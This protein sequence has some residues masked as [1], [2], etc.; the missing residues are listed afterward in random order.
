MNRKKKLTAA[1]FKEKIFVLDGAMGTMLQRYNLQENDYRGERFAGHSHPLKGNGDIL[2]LTQPHI[3]RDIHVA[4]LDAGADI[5]ET[6][7]FNA[8]SISQADYDTQD[9]VEEINVEAARLAVEAADKFMH[10]HPGEIKYVAGVMGPTNKT[11]SLSPDVNN[12]GYRNVSF[13]ELETTYY[14]QAV[15]LARGGVDM[16]LIETVFDTLNAKAALAAISRFNKGRKEKIRAMVSGTITDPSGRT[17]IGQ[18][19]SG[20]YAA[21]RHGDLLSV[22]LNCAFGASQLRPFIRELSKIAEFPVSVHPN[23]GLPNEF[24]EYEQ[25]AGEMAGILKEYLEEGWVNILG[26]CC[27]TTPE[28]VRQVFR[29]AQNYQPRAIPGKQNALKIAGLEAVTIHS[30]K[31]FVNIGERTNVAGSKRFARLIREEQFEE[32]LEVARHQIEN[33]AQVIDICMDDAMLDGKEAMVKFLRNIQAEP[34]IAIKPVMID[35]SDWKIIEE[36]LKNTSGKPIVNS[37]SLKEG[38]ED[39]LQKAETLKRYGA[40]VVVMLFDEQGQAASYRDKIRIARRS[41]DLLTEKAEFPAEDIIFDPN[42]LAVA[43]GIEEHNNYAVDFLNAI[44]WIKENLPHAKISGGVSN[45]SFSFRGNNRVREALHSVFLYH[46]TRAG[47]DMGIVNPALLE[48]YDD[49]DKDLKNLAE[50][51][52]LNKRKDATER[53]ISF[54]ESLSQTKET[55]QKADEWRR[56]PLEERIEYSLVKGID[57]YVEEDAEQ[58]RQHFDSIIDIIE[59]PLMKGMDV[60]GDLFGSGKMFLPQVVKSARVMKKAVGYLQPF[61]EKEL[62][63]GAETS[64]AGRIVLAT[65]KGDVHDI[66]KNIV[67]VILTCNNYEVIDLG[68]MVPAEKI[69]ETAEKVK[70]DIIGLSGLITPSLHEMESVAH[71]MEKRGM[72]T[73]LL[74]GGATTSKEHTAVKIAPNYSAPV[75]HVRDAS[76]AASTA[77]GLINEE[78]KED[79]IREIDEK[80]EQTRQKHYQR[81]QAK[82]YL[83]LEEA[84]SNKRDINWQAEKIVKPQFLGNKLIDDYPLESLRDYIDWTFFFY[85]WDLKGK[86]PKIFDDPLKGEEAKKLFEDGKELLD[87]IISNKWLKAKVLLGFYPVMS[88]GDDVW[89][90]EKKDDEKPVEVFNFLRNQ[91]RRDDGI[92]PCLADFVR[93]E[94]NGERDYAGFFIVSTGFGSDQAYRYFA[95]KN[96][97]Y[98]AIMVRVLADRLAEAL[99]ERLHEEVRT[100]YWGYC[101]EE[102][103][104]KDELLKEVYQGIR[105]AIGYPSLPDHSEKEKLFNLLDPKK[106]SG[107]TLTESYMMVPAASV[108]GYYLYHP[109]SKYF[110]VGKIGKDQLG[111]YARRKGITEEEAE[112]LLARNLNY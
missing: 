25:T 84:R 77:A 59:G 22:G 15:A 5:I 31:N 6:N 34:D 1:D 8:N 57:K 95:E 102:N 97:D 11:A 46:A 44:K 26:G 70:A 82:K 85:A 30:G 105:P 103:L 61:L 87:E 3:I 29:L 4:Y 42:I 71:E 89:V 55:T 21:I 35:S 104:S 58:A 9:L 36:G 45:L 60:V 91:Q 47:L 73:P 75:V 17:L 62:T 68:V 99:A 78:R 18:T 14:D 51:V 111:D 16:F 110:D 49:I 94:G 92:N 41:Y 74:I 13:D 79:Y 72:N 69:L 56:K 67:N 28:H 32:A 2:C 50:E 66:G 27:G 52:V 96:D 65:V 19:V 48:V 109:Q 33:G 81:R 12:P 86:Y 100:N 63:E 38:E 23:A 101:P 53:L 10:D 80:Q 83:S 43:T 76:Q 93:P 98:R 90:F 7:T 88:R 108:S 24:G 64:S 107:I 106:K 40:A 112:K 39:F 20:F 37:I 54:A